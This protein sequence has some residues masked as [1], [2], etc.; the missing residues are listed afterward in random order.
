MYVERQRQVRL[1][2]AHLEFCAKGR[3][4]FS[5][6]HVG[7]W[8]GVSAQMLARLDA[9]NVGEGIGCRG[10]TLGVQW[11]REDAG[12]ARAWATAITSECATRSSGR[13][14]R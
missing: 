9:R 8:V 14:E 6:G 3:H 2:E 4:V 12:N 5:L 7:D 10:S 13:S 11:R 1:G